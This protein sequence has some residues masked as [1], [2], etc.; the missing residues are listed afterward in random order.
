ML[1]GSRLSG[2]VTEVESPLTLAEQEA[3]SFTAGLQQQMRI[4]RHAM[5]M[6]AAQLREH[7]GSNWEAPPEDVINLHS[8]TTI[9]VGSEASG[10][11]P[12]LLLAAGLLAGGGGVA[13]GLVALFTSPTTPV[14][15]SPETGSRL[16]EQEVTIIIESVDGEVTAK[17]KE[18]RNDR[19]KARANP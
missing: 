1:N 6:G 4:D 5:A 19:P 12:K 11:L 8:P 17:V 10:L 3:M 14:Q 2:Q 9:N 13:L 15:E 7:Y 16:S 18:D